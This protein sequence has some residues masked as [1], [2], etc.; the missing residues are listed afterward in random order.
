M[1]RFRIRRA[2]AVL[3]LVPAAAVL[4]LPACGRV[5]YDAIGEATLPPDDLLGLR[6][7]EADRAIGEARTALLHMDDALREF[8]A[9][10]RGAGASTPRVTTATL[11][12]RC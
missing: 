9:S 5:Y 10:Q 2:F 7:T 12:D 11:W 8:D 1:T 6:I 3:L 4:M